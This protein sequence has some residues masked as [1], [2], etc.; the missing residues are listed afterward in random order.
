MCSKTRT[1]TFKMVAILEALVKYHLPQESSVSSTFRVPAQNYLAVDSFLSGL[2]QAIEIW[3]VFV[4]TSGSY[5]C[6][7]FPKICPHRP[8]ACPGFCQ[9]F[10]RTGISHWTG[11]SQVLCS[12]C[13]E[14]L[15]RCK[16]TSSSRRHPWRQQLVLNLLTSPWLERRPCAC[17]NNDHDRKVHHVEQ[18]CIFMGISRRHPRAQTRFSYFTPSKPRMP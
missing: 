5:I 7:K 3:A 10:V 13:L 16:V 18:P 4:R 11:L 8:M 12:L 9:I 17:L 6:R 1:G 15:S 2:D 14:V